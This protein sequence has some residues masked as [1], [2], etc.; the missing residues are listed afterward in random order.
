V[1]RSGTTRQVRLFSPSQAH[2]LIAESSL[3]AAVPQVLYDA[4]GYACAGNGE[5]DHA[6]VPTLEG[7]GGLLGILGPSGS[8][9]TTLLSILAG[10][11]TPAWGRVLLDGEP[12]DA[13]TPLRIGYVPQEDVLYSFL[14]VRETL[15][16]SARLCAPPA[17][18]PW[19]PL[20]LPSR[21]RRIAALALLPYSPP[22]L[23]PS[24]AASPP[25][26]AG[27]VWTRLFRRWD[28]LASQTRPSVA[29][30]R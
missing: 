5:A 27:A 18:R 16:L 13:D 20:S 21:A 1:D 4:Y 24:G 15:T 22:N 3:W 23:P 28:S 14:T 12:Y 25:W 17:H 11:T 29:L 9:K 7:E 8:G 10:H 30:A 6:G 26:T 19:S 2:T